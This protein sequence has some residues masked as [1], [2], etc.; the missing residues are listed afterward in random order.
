M[1]EI[2]IKNFRMIVRMFA[3]GTT[4]IAALCIFL[5]NPE[6]IVTEYGTQFRYHNSFLFTLMYLNVSLH[7]IGIAILH[8]IW[9]RTAKIKRQRTQALVFLFVL[10]TIGPIGFI[11]DFIIPIYY[12]FTVVPLAAFAVL[13]ISVPIWV[14]MRLNQTLSITVPNVSGYI[15]KSVTLPAL[16]LDYKNI[17]GLENESSLEFFGRSLLGESFA[18]HM[19]IEDNNP[20]QTFFDTEHNHDKITVLTSQGG[21]TC[22]LLLTIESDSNNDAICKV[23]ILRDISENEYNEKLLKSLNLSTSYLLNSDIESFDDNLYHAVMV[24][25]EALHV[26]RIDIWKTMLNDEDLKCTIVYEWLD[27]NEQTKPDSLKNST[28]SGPDTSGWEESMQRGDS[29][30]VVIQSLNGADDQESSPVKHSVLMI[31]VFLQSRF[32]GYVGFCAYRKERKFTDIEESVA[33]SGSLMFANAYQRNEIIQDMHNTSKQLETT[34]ENSEIANQA[35]SD[36]LAKISHEIRTPMNS[37][38]GFSE[39]ALDGSDFDKA[40]EYLRNILR[41]SEWMLQIVDDILDISKIESGKMRLENIPFDLSSVFEACKMII[42]PTTEEKGLKLSFYVE[43]LPGRRLYGDPVRLKQIIINLLSNAV[44]FTNAGWVKILTVVQEVELNT[45]TMLFEISDSGIG[46]TEE[47]KDKILDPFT[48]AETGTTRKYGGS[49]LGL[50]IT[51]NIIDLMGGKLSVE[52]SPGVGSKFSF[53]LTFDTAPYENNGKVYER[54]AHGVV[55]PTFEGEVLLCE[56]NA[57]NQQLACEHL[58]R[59]GLKATVAKNGAIGVDF[60][61]K[62]EENNEK[63]FDIVFMDIHMPEMDGLEAASKILE[64]NKDIPIVALT[65]NI[66]ES[67]LERYRNNGMVDCL[68]KPFTTRKMWDLLLKYLTPIDNS[69]V[70]EVEPPDLKK[71]LAKSFI[72]SN[73]NKYN[74][75]T[76]ALSAGD[77]KLTHRLVHTLKGNAAQIGEKKLQSI[78]KEIE[79]LLSEDGVIFDTDSIDLN[80]LNNVHMKNLEQELTL[81]LEKLEA[82]ISNDEIIKAE[83]INDKSRILEIL[84]KLEQLI[85]DND[86]DCFLYLDDLK[87]IRGGAEPAA[88][89]ENYEFNKALESILELKSGLSAKDGTEAGENN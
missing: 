63:Q 53:T 38:I 68:G 40:K 49:G 59:V 9:Y 3:F 20:D 85:T 36:F 54:R 8:I 6:F 17:V 57:M 43:A 4:I 26:E 32:W 18:D 28:L 25:G 7:I 35:K 47:Q 84:Q 22:D 83:Q 45:V 44:K 42:M 21:K 39:L 66:M 10:I 1:L 75:I 5:G 41:N 33:R 77:I 31:P 65:A 11:T 86:T 58:S 70:H 73:Q 71:T 60:I 76:E 2:K 46:M 52:S 61:R 51:N 16:V 56:D 48:Q 15:F 13:L 64:I 82:M 37:I 29:V 62:R 72:R 12:D 24:V 80:Q 88:Y 81:I 69:I 67:D 87:S 55:K 74:E 34:L 30:S 23:L 50:A 27:S 79:D 14:L 19:L 89:M 78:S